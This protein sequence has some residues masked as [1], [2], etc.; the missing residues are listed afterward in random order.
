MPRSEHTRLDDILAAAERIADFSAGMTLDEFRDDLR[1]VH[2]VLHNIAIIGEAAKGVS[3]MAD[4][5]LRRFPGWKWQ[6]CAM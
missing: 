2:A 4:L 6:E 3:D 1:T 5:L